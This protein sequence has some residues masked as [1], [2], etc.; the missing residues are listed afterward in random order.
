[1]PA[2]ALDPGAGAPFAADDSRPISRPAELDD[3]PASRVA[4]RDRVEFSD[5]R[6]NSEL[7][8]EAG[9]AAP[10]EAGGEGADSPG[11]RAAEAGPQAASPAPEF[12]RLAERQARWAGPGIRLAT[13]LLCALLLLSLAG[14]AALQFRD[15]LAATFPSARLALETL[16]EAAGCRIEPLR[17]IDDIVIESSELKSI[18]ASDAARLSVALR[19][20]GALPLAMPSIELTLT[21][22]GGQMIARR[23]LSPAEFGVGDATLPATGEAT[24]Q[25]TLAVSGRRATGYTVEPFYP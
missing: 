1:M 9:I 20:R 5:A 12:L 16:C 6:F 18:P 3:T 25:L 15:L 11:E 7:L 19:N 8:A 21:D 2:P 23:A 10:V 4:A 14:Q 13:T 24:L 17:R 22:P